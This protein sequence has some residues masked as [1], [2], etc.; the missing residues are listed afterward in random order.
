MSSKAEVD[1][2]TANWIPWSAGDS[3]AAAATE[4][5]GAPVMAVRA[6]ATTADGVFEVLV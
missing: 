5:I 6:K 4:V 2:G 1:A 3:A